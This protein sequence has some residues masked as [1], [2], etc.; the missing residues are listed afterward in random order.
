MSLFFCWWGESSNKADGGQDF[1]FD[2]AS[3]EIALVKFIPTKNTTDWPAFGEGNSTYF[4]GKSML[5]E[6][7]GQIEENTCSVIIF[8]SHSANIAPEKLPSQ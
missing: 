4:K 7:F 8:R 5:V 3:S 1:G 2:L 6:I